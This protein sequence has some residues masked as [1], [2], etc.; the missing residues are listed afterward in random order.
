ML[1][2]Y[3]KFPLIVK[4]MPCRKL[5]TYNEAARQLG[6]HPRTIGNLIRKGLLHCYRFEGKQKGVVEEEVKG[7]AEWWDK[8]RRKK[9]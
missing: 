2:G 6:C 4:P 8:C 9:K 7:F 1:S 3:H 5:I